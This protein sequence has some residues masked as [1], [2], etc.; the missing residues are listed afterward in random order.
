MVPIYK[1]K[2]DILE[3]NNYRGIKLICHSMKLG[4]IIEA[5]LRQIF[6]L[7]SLQEKYRDMNGELRRFGE[8]IRSSTL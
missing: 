3:C 4:T 6:K 7:R 2:G 1:G 8:G 5:G